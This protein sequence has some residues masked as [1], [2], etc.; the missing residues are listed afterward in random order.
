MEFIFQFGEFYGTDSSN[1]LGGLGVLTSVITLVVVVWLHFKERIDIRNDYEFTSMDLTKNIINDIDSQINSIC[2]YNDSLKKDILN[3]SVQPSRMILGNLEYLI[4]LDL[5]I[6][7]RVFKNNKNTTIDECNL[8]LKKT[9]FF[10]QVFNNFYEQHFNNRDLINSM[11]REYFPVFMDNR[12]KLYQ[13][14]H[15]IMSTKYPFTIKQGFYDFNH[16][17]YKILNDYKKNIN[18]PQGEKLHDIRFKL[19]KP[20]RETLNEGYNK[21]PHPPEDNFLTRMNFNLINMERHVIEIEKIN[22]SESN[23]IFG[24]L[25]YWNSSL[26]EIREV[27]S[28]F[29]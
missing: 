13:L 2:N 18:N 26:N 1:W 20:L 3:M 14:T 23:E 11:N 5:T 21:F 8:L 9:H 12:E 28:K 22:Q 4:D 17:M 7:H 10:I 6:L 25:D 16:S 27:Y 29:Q 24:S 19:L 15:E